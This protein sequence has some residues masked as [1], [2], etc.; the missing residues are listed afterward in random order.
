MGWIAY[1]HPLVIIII[2]IA[3]VAVS[4]SALLMNLMMIKDA[5]NAHVDKTEPIQNSEVLVDRIDSD[6]SLEHWP[7]ICPHK[8]HAAI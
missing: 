4:F 7:P 3:A 6:T 8:L 5:A 2:I 1:L